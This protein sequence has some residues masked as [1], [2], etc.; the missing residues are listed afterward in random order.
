[1]SK[2]IQIRNVPDEVHRALKVRAASEGMSLSDY[3]LREVTKVAE[4]PTL[5]EFF[6]RV[7]RREPV[8]LDEDPAVTIRRLRG[9]M[10]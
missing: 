3:L 5:D 6:S 10:P 2:M 8:V 7:R 9:P 4:R 1:M